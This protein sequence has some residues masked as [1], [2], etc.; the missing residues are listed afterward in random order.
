MRVD[1]IDSNDDLLRVG[2]YNVGIQQSMLEK[3]K[4]RKADDRLDRLATDIADS[5]DTHELDLLGHLPLVIAAGPLYKMG[6]PELTSRNRA[7]V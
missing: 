1:R 4:R 5:F 7:D 6:G 3:T 2:F